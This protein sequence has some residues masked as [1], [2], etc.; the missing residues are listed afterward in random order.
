M[1]PWNLRIFR[2]RSGAPEFILPMSSASW[3]SRLG[4]NGTGN[5]A[6]KLRG[7][8]IPRSFIREIARGNKYTLAHCWGDHVA[9][10]GVIQN[11]RYSERA[12]LLQLYSKEL[13]AAIFNKRLTHG[14]NEYN[15]QGGTLSAVN[16]SHSGAARIVL[17]AATKADAVPGWEL[18]LTLPAGG[19]GTFNAVWWHDEGLTVE[20]M[21]AQIE[22]EGIEIGFAP[23]IDANGYLRW[24]T[25][26][27]APIMTGTPFLLPANAP[28]TIVMDPWSEEDYAEQYTGLLGFG[29]GYGEDR[30]W[31]YSPRVGDGIG[32]LPVMD[33]RTNFDRLTD[34][35]RLNKANDVEF[36]SRQLPIEQWDY[37][38]FIGGTG[39]AIAAPGRVHDL[40]T[41]GSLFNNDGSHLLRVDALSGGLNLTV[42]PEVT[43]V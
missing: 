33:T 43:R 22:A 40:H 12:E 23:S 3:T 37:R 26:V 28:G 24:T 13:R 38:L 25:Q 20:N 36:A 21:L 6:S 1:E 9:Y 19:A 5:H 30:P 8:G 35:T 18:P 15:P 29:K 11:R 41:Y 16:Q 39:P 10:A 14:V 34:Q 2:T 17:N 4:S 7:L 27:G 31:T 42:E 32:D